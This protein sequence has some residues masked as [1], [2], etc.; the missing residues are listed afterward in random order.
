V[1][2]TL[3]D[4]LAVCLDMKTKLPNCVVEPTAVASFTALLFNLIIAILTLS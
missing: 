4:E 3:A 1:K 2:L